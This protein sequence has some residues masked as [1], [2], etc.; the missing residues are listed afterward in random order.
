[1][2]FLTY[3]DEERQYPLI[4]VNQVG[5]YCNA[6]KT[7]RVSYFE[8]FG[9]LNGKTYEIVSAET[10]E[11][12]ASGTLSDA[13]YEESFSGKMVHTITF[14]EVTEPGTYYIRIPNTRLD[15]SARSPYDTADELELDTLTSVKFENSDN[16]YDDLLSDL[17]K[18]YYYQRQGMEIEGEYTGIFA[19]ENLHPDDITVKKWSDRDNRL[20]HYRGAVERY[21][22]QGPMA[23]G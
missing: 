3:A 19:R 12:A 4:K 14:D 1:M 7:A 16:V 8:K 21:R 22:G 9:S 17:T 10:E 23:V 2:P 20:G 13:V 5:Y 18:Y 15:E 11:I 6:A